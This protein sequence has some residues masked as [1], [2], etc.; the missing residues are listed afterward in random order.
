MQPLFCVRLTVSICSVPSRGI[1]VASDSPILSVELISR[2]LI[3]TTNHP[4][5]GT[6]HFL[7]KVVALHHEQSSYMYG[8][9]LNIIGVC[10]RRWRSSKRNWS[11]ERPLR[12]KPSSSAF[13]HKPPRNI[14][15]AITWLDRQGIIILLDLYHILG[16]CGILRHCSKIAYS[17]PCQHDHRAVTRCVMRHL[18]AHTFLFT[19]HGMWAYGACVY[20]T[21]SKYVRGSTAKF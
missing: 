16:H 4:S 5:H 8:A 14:S 2:V 9:L 20:I 11:V 15:Y 6:Q 3:V 1:G 19:V 12:R 18:W 17:L 13:H 21:Y 7:S 10:E